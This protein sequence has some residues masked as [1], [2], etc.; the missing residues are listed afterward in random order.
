MTTLTES[1]TGTD[2]SKSELLNILNEIDAELMWGQVPIPD[3]QNEN[4]NDSEGS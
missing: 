1:S 4:D 2:L 3:T